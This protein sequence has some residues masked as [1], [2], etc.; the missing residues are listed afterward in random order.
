MSVAL[1]H[2]RVRTGLRVLPETRR[3]AKDQRGD[4]GDNGAREDPQSTGAQPLTER[5]R[6]LRIMDIRGVEVADAGPTAH[7]SEN[8]A[9]EL[10]AHAVPRV[11]LIDRQSPQAD[12]GL[13]WGVFFSVSSDDMAKPTSSSSAYS[14]RYQASSPN[15]VCDS[16][17]AFAATNP[18]RSAATAS[19]VTARTDSLVL[20]VNSKTPVQPARSPRLR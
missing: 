6:T 17:I 14:A 16:D 13:G 12:A 1:A 5:S 3:R 18:C 8:K 7:V 15:S 9:Y 20:Q 11:L 19:F 4:P 2:G 10:A